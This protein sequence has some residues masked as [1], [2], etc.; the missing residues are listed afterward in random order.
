MVETGRNLYNQ[1]LQEK[2]KS[3][4]GY[5]FSSFRS[6]MQGI[7]I[8]S[9]RKTEPSDKVPE[10][11][12]TGLSTFM[13]EAE[14]EQARRQAHEKS[15]R[16]AEQRRHEVGPEYAIERNI[17]ETPNLEVVY[18]ADVA[19]VVPTNPLSL[20]GSHEFIDIGNGDIAPQWGVDLLMHGGTLT[21]GPWADRQRAHLQKALF[22][23]TYANISP[24]VRLKPGDTRVCTEF[25]L[26]LELNEEAKLRVPTREKSKD[27]QFDQ[28]PDLGQSRRNMAQVGCT[29]AA[30]STLTYMMP[31]VA[32]ETGYA[33]TLKIRL[34]QICMDSSLNNKVF[35]KAEA[36]RVSM[37]PS[38]N[39]MFLKPYRSSVN[40]QHLCIGEKKGN[41]AFI[42]PSNSRIF[43][44]FVIILPYLP[45][46][47]K[48]GALDRR[49]V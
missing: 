40:S 38:I 13:T 42:L 4:M 8:F 9:P 7:P 29:I 26:F 19:G 15:K 31:I 39:A 45:I 14:R 25:R 46:S 36:C 30:N 23:P 48:I 2:P 27:W 49:Q 37:T 10:K 16:L 22:P 32:S 28:L 18:Y 33:T 41:G 43:T 24:T 5:T 20:E 1:I 35:L 34:T 12:W 3:I 11:P 6:L 21:Y 44:S 17:L 47:G